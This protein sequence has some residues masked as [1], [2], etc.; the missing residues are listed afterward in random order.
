[1]DLTKFEE[2]DVIII[3]GL[4]RSGKSHFAKK[5]FESTDRS[6]INRGELRK[7]LYTMAHFGKEWR[8]TDFNNEDEVLV[9]HVERKVIEHYIHNNRKI[10]IDNTSV[11]KESRKN[12]IS[13]AKHKNKSLGVI[14]IE[15]PVDLCMKRNK[16]SGDPVPERVITNLYVKTEKPEKSEGFK[17][18]LIVDDYK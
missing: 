7:S 17:E 14:F 8:E 11:T 2:L 18:I 5:F 1:M 4:P 10:I 16:E 13:I 3:C 6:R 15:N 9:K 12:Y